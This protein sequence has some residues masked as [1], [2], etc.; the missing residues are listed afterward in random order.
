MDVGVLLHPLLPAGEVLVPLEHLACVVGDDVRGPL[1][2]LVQVVELVLVVA[3]GAA[4][5]RALR[6]QP[7]VPG[8]DLL[9]R[10]RAVADGVPAVDEGRL[11]VRTALDRTV[12]VGVVGVRGVVAAVLDLVIG[13][14]RPT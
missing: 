13:P 11:A 12:A 5:E 7:V 14:P 2:V 1:H 8:P 6:R 4:A 3:S 10:H 9:P